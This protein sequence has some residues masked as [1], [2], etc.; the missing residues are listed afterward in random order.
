MP[1]PSKR[2]LPASPRPV[3]CGGCLRR[4]TSFTYG[5]WGVARYQCRRC[6]VA[7]CVRHGTPLAT[8][9]ER[10]ALRR[11]RP[12]PECRSRTKH[13]RGCSRSRRARPLE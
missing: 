2:R 10:L 5:S 6:A 11:F 3:V 9:I 7:A 1:I 4:L 12:C 13:R 8:I